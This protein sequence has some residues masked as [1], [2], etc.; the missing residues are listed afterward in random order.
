[1]SQG[2]FTSGNCAEM[3]THANRV[4]RQVQRGGDVKHEEVFEGETPG[5]TSHTARNSS[6]P[7]VKTHMWP[8]PG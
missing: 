3:Q 1:M 8:K 7:N 2:E 5:H 6:F 4:S